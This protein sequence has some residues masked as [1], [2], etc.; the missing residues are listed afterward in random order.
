MS[1]A[2]TLQS[3]SFDASIDSGAGTVAVGLYTGS[4]TTP[5]TLITSATTTIAGAHQYN[6]VSL[7]AALTNAEHIWMAFLSDT[8][9]YNLIY[10]TASA[11]AN[12]YQDGGLTYPTFNSTFQDDNHDAENQIAAYITY[13]TGTSSSVPL[14]SFR[15]INLI[16]L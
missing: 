4:A 12:Y 15:P 16:S 11:G 13:S 9:C 1:E 8:D 6:T 10:K 14:R 3:A 2:G 5:S 7:S